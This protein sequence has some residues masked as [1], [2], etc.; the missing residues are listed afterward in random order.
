[1]EE[2]RRAEFPDVR[3]RRIKTGYGGFIPA[4]QTDEKSQRAK[5]RSKN[6]ADCPVQEIFTQSHTPL[7]LAGQQYARV[8]K[9]RDS[10][11]GLSPPVRSLTF[12]ARS[13][14]R[15]PL[16]E[17]LALRNHAGPWERHSLFD[18][19]LLG[20]LTPTS[21]ETHSDD[22]K[23]SST[24]IDRL[25][26]ACLAFASHKP[27]A[28]R[29]GRLRRAIFNSPL[30]NSESEQSA[31]C[32]PSSHVGQKLG[33]QRG[34]DRD[35]MRTRKE[36]DGTGGGS[37][38]AYASSEKNESGHEARCSGQSASPNSAP[39]PLRPSRS[40]LVRRAEVQRQGYWR[41]S[42]QSHRRQPPRGAAQ[43]TPRPGDPSEEEKMSW[44]PAHARLQ[45]WLARAVGSIAQRW[46]FLEEQGLPTAMHAVPARGA[47]SRILS[48]SWMSSL[49]GIANGIGD[50]ACGLQPRLQA[51]G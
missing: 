33:P 7:G 5:P 17:T 42:C 38:W 21:R 46:D 45:V 31:T 15:S 47:D 26:T 36:R 8:R 6:T 40:G 37:R 4:R 50:L 41:G 19:N 35:H 30:A 39:D 28:R 22:S 13:P 11:Q 2:R 12:S 14:A 10:E 18:G 25:I 44:L 49:S 1:M 24:Q 29:P 9:F 3:P 32:R 34:T 43:L 20:E 16:S 48:R 27:T 23:G 51:V